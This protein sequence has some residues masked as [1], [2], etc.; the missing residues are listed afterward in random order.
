ML[1]KSF[2]RQTLI[3]SY[4]PTPNSDRR[5][6]PQPAYT[7]VAGLLEDTID[8]RGEMRL[9]PLE[10]AGDIKLQ[11]ARFDFVTSAAAHVGEMTLCCVSL[12]I[13]ELLLFRYE[14]A[15]SLRVF[16]HENRDCEL[17]VI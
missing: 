16:E 13:T 4:Y 15:C 12:D 6:S 3:F 17:E 5:L 9:D 10:V 14:P 7:Q 1:R 2:K 8:S 11:R